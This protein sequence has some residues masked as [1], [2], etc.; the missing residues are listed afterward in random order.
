MNKSRLTHHVSRLFPFLV[1]SGFVL[2]FFQKMA[3]SNLILARGDTFLYFYP[4][5]QAA[6][7]ALRNGRVP[8]WNPN[9]FMGAPFLANSQAGFFYPLNWPVWWLLPTPYAVS[10]S[11]IVHLMIA[12][13]GTYLVG[14]RVLSLSRAGALLAALLFA[15]GGYLTAQIEHINQLQGLAWLPWFLVVL[16]SGRA[17]GNRRMRGER[18]VMLRQGTAVAALFSLQLLAGHTQ[19][20]F[21]TGIGIALYLITDYGLRITDFRSRITHHALRFAFHVLPLVIGVVLA[22]LITAVQLLPTLELSQF[23]SRQGGL[24]VNEVLSFSLHPLLLGRSLLPGYGQSLFSEYVAFLP[25]TALLLAGVGLWHW[26]QRREVRPIIVVAGTAF[27]L[28][29]GRFTPLYWLLARLP[30]FDLFRVPARWLV[31]YALGMALLAGLGWD[32]VRGFWCAARE[33]WR[34]KLSRPLRWG[35]ALIVVLM[36]WSLLAVPL[37]RFLPLGLE[38]PAAYPTWPTIA[39][40]LLELTMLLILWQFRTR[41]QSFTLSPLHLVTLSFLFFASRSLPYNQLT[42]PEAYFDLRPS[43]TRLQAAQINQTV[44]GRLLSLSNIFFDP[45]DQAEIDTIYADQLSEQARYDY[46]VA[47]KQKEIIAP[48][49]PLAYGLASVDGFDGGILPLHSYSQLMRTILPDQTSTVDGRLREYLTAVPQPEWLDLFNA[50]YLITDKTGD[51]WQEI[52]PGFSVFFDLQHLVTIAAGQNLAVGYV[53]DFPATGLVL[54]ADGEVGE[55]TITATAGRISRTFTPQP[56]G[57]NLW[58]IDWPETVTLESIV[59]TASALADWQIKG[60]TLVNWDDQTFQPL[61]PGH[62]RLLHSGDVK[63]YENLDVLPRAFLVADWQWVVDEETAVTHM[64]Q[65]DFNPRKTAVLLGDGRLVSGQLA[66]EGT[67]VS[68]VTYEPEQVVLQV[69]SQSEAL[70]VLTDTNYPGW[71]AA[72]DGQPVPIFTADVLFRAIAVPAGRHEIVFS[73]VSQSFVN[74]RLLSLLG[75][76]IWLLLVVVVFGAGK[77]KRS[78]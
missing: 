73:F 10:A 11:I 46:T 70:L 29:L 1:I 55:V 5:W 45:G 75:L 78:M 72:I 49:L 57:E 64:Q 68:V 7:G 13:W 33:E 48:N 53:P 52:A 35:A 62:Y 9:L 43:M 2:L 74:G 4:Y 41:I 24:A 58:R 28:A 54:L 34:A 60:L 44:P 18:R 42:T 21:I 27:I 59:L 19:T 16:G 50:R 67:A 30:G 36:V 6:A 25:L 40:W 20:A 63:I 8:L 76:A 38:A 66:D 17:A 39:G 23:S 56:L 77:I 31:W 14:R 12:G 15:L 3:F 69:E 71:Q 32:V 61:V 37:A 26:R 51:V 22:G 47:I 65:P